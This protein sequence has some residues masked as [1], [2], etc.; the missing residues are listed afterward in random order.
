MLL[1]DIFRLNEN[2]PVN[3][4]E[5]I[6]YADDLPLQYEIA[7]LPW[8][9]TPGLQKEE[10]EKSLYSLLKSQFDIEILKT[11]ENLQIILA[12]E[13]IAKMLETHVGTPCFQIE[14]F[15]Y[16]KNGNIIEYSKAFFHGE[17]ASF[18]IERNYH[19]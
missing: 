10:C 14:T 8:R 5:R 17:R 15:A 9:E 12:D 13:K 19:E 2:D 4:L 3:K 18:V 1:Q 7:Y 6:R 11:E 16:N